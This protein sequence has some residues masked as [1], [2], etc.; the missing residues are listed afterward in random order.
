MTTAKSPRRAAPRATPKPEPKPDEPS[1]VDQ[2]AEDAAPPEYPP[3]V[4]EFLTPLAVK[5]RSRRAEFKRRYAVV[6]ERYEAIVKY[7]AIVEAKE[8]PPMSEQLRISAEL[9]EVGQAIDD[10]L[11]F[12][13][14]DPDAYEAWSAEVEDNDLHTTFNVYQK[15]AQ[16]GEASSSTS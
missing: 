9:D 1:V 14:V 3:G 7:R 4:P 8:N 15:R 5:P 13:A 12:V 2:L 11:R 10:M 16:P 6:V